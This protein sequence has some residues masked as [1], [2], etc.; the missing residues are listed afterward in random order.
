MLAA[1]ILPVAAI[2]SSGAPEVISKI[3]PTAAIAEIEAP[4]KQKPVVGVY[5]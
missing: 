5:I 3:E 2:P 4:S 1:K